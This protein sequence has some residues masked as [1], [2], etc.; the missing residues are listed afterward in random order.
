METKVEFGVFRVF[1]EVGISKSE[2]S[3][4]TPS[5]IQHSDSKSWPLTPDLKSKTA[6]L[7]MNGCDSYSAIYF[8]YSWFATCLSFGLPRKMYHNISDRFDLLM[9]SL[10][11]DKNK[12]VVFLYFSVWVLKKL[13]NALCKHFFFSNFE[14]ETYSGRN[15]IIILRE[16][17]NWYIFR[18]HSATG[19]IVFEQVAC[20][21]TRKQVK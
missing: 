17:C 18:R 15:I 9:A 16:K 2:K 14:L 7:H 19:R 10:S 8:H 20:L 12:A 11:K 3:T 6:T 4:V 13:H 5:Q 1:S 21:S